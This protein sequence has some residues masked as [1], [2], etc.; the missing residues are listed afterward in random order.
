MYISH[1]LSGSHSALHSF[2]SAIFPCNTCPTLGIKITHRN[3]QYWVPQY[4]PLSTQLHLWMFIS[5]RFIV[6]VWGFWLLWHNQYWLLTG[7]SL[8]YSVVALC[9]RDPEGFDSETG[10]F[11]IP[12]RSPMIKV[13]QIKALDEG[14]GLDFSSCWL[15]LICTTRVNH[16]AML[17]LGYQ[18]HHL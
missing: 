6:L 5:T 8:I 17:W 12:N 1:N 9:H 16:S 2:L 4:R 11:M 10:S 18:Y 13:S 15:S 3:K 14:I 7:P